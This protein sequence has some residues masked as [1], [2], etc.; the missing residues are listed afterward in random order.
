MRNRVQIISCHLYPFSY[1]K[2]LLSW[3]VKLF[4]IVGIGLQGFSSLRSH[5]VVVL[6]FVEGVVEVELGSKFYDIII[7]TFLSVLHHGPICLG[8]LVP[9][10]QRE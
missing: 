10:A 8:Y 6:V 2:S 3:P 7:S 9:F 1:L 4:F 5:Q